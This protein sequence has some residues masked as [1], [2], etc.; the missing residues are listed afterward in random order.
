M[1]VTDCDALGGILTTVVVIF[2]SIVHQGP[3]SIQLNSNN[4]ECCAIICHRN[5]ELPIVFV[6]TL[7]TNRALHDRGSYLRIFKSTARSLNYIFGL[8]HLMPEYIFV[9]KLSYLQCNF[10]P[11]TR[12]ALD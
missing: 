7:K 1:A 12:C 10:F 5:F 9:L 3:L 2:E 11:R 8:E 6:L 4:Q